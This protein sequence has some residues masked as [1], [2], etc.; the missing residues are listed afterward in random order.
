VKNITVAASEDKK[1]SCPA[2]GRQGLFI[3]VEKID[4]Y[5]IRRCSFCYL[6]FT[7]SMDYDPAY[8]EQLHY[9]DDLNIREFLDLD[10][11]KFLR[12]AASFLNDKN[13]Q[14]HNSVLKWISQ[15]FKSSSVICDIGCGVGWF[16]A[17]LEIKGYHVFGIEVST[18][19]VNALNA[20]GF[21][22]Y[23][24]PIETIT[25]PL[26]IPDLVVLMN[27]I[28]HVEDPLSLLHNIHKRFPQARL[29]V[30]LPSPRRW[31]LKVGLRHYSDYPPNHLT[32]F[33]SKESLEMVLQR[34]GYIL[35]DWYFPGVQNGEIWMLSLDWF[36]LKIGLRR[37]GFFVGLTSSSLF[38]SLNL[39]QKIIKT[40]IKYFYL[41]MEKINKF[42]RYIADPLLNVIS[43]KLMRKNYTGLTAIAAARPV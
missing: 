30:T 11:D 35:D 18:K 37:K 26:P 24:G 40:T 43:K 34:A 2:C 39:F 3:Q 42:L 9:A 29:L 5:I 21:Q 14:P 8:Y 25:A 23:L 1:I 27:V 7:E 12:M 20:K 6:E 28:E 13:W 31:D 22:C 10:N 15:N 33:W 17:A 36:F 4:K 32:P 41:E 19:I 16:L 38:E